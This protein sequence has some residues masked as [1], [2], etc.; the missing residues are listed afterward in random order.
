MNYN[1]N[2]QGLVPF[3]S[4]VLDVLLGTVSNCNIPLQ[5]PDPEIMTFSYFW[6][7]KHAPVKD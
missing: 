7:L 2:P 3:Y 1:P 5:P 4:Y 6:A